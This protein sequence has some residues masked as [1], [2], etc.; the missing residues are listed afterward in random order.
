MKT[1]KLT[2][3]FIAL[4][5]IV[6]MSQKTQA[7]LVLDFD[8]DSYGNAIQAGQ[9]ID[10]EY[11]NWGI[12]ISAYN[13]YGPDY[14]ITFDTANPT[15]ND[16]DLA[17]P[18]YNN[19]AD[20][21]NVL[22]LPSYITDSNSDGL[23][24]DPNDQAGTNPGSITFTFDEDQYGTVD[25]NFLDIEE[26]G[27]GFDLYLDNVWLGSLSIGILGD[28]GYGELSSDFFGD[29]TFDQ[30]VVNFS[31]SGAIGSVTF[32]TVTV[33]EPASMSLL[34]VGALMI[35]MRPKRNRVA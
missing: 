25:V 31:G 1:T 16:S 34:A 10:N 11:A 14:A 23:V 22:I 7:A 20:L 30:I 33:P 15:G 3:M 2:T 27:T 5:T 26:R 13:K 35:G 6:M 24:D 28:N 17:T 21:D 32:D 8:T 12:N 19:S 29:L 18:G 4:L 9:F